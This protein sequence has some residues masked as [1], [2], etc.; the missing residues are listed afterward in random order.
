MPPEESFDIREIPF[1]AMGGVYEQDD[2]EAAMKVVRAVA[3]AGGDF[4]P[5][6]EETEF[7]D[8]LA[9]HEGAAKAIAVNS[10]GT[11]LNLCMMVLGIG[12]GDGFLCPCGVSTQNL[13]N[14]AA[15]EDAR[16]VRVGW[17]T[18]LEAAAKVLKNKHI[19][20]AL[21]V[22][23]AVDLAADEFEKDIKH[24]LETLEQIDNISLLL[25]HTGAET[26]DENICRIV[27]TI[28]TFADDKGVELTDT[29]SCCI[30]RQEES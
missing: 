11:A 20:A 13:E 23:R 21:D 27:E 29:S 15:V 9:K 28:R 1:G 30:T 4:F 10:C 7:Q 26:P 14:F 17:G 12:P 5:L 8:A 16:Y 19:K 24:I 25:I 2:I 18:D 22:V 6:P 3:E